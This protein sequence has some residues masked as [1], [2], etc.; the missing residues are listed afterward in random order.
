MGWADGGGLVFGW[1]LDEGI[2]DPKQN[3]PVGGYGNAVAALERHT[4]ADSRAAGLAHLAL[5]VLP[6]TGLGWLLQRVS[7]DRPITRLVLTTLATWTVLGGRSLQREG[8][9]VAAL[10]A[11]HD[12]PEAR[13]RIRSL[14]G[15]DPE[16]LDAE[17]LARAAVESVAENTS[18]AVVAPLF[19]GALFGIPGL[20][21]YRA[22]NTLDAMIGHHNER[23]ERFGWAAARLD[24]LVN[25]APARLAALLTVPATFF[26]GGN[27]A[28]VWPVVRRDAGKHPSPNAGRIEAAFAGGLG[29]RLGGSNSYGGRWED[30]GTLGDGP[31]PTPDDLPRTTMLSALVGGFA[32]MS[33]GHLARVRSNLTRRAVRPKSVRPPA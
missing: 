14:V 6:V 17:G 12:L 20:L 24:D 19:W 1:L 2:G 22:I 4:Y 5:A 27:A 13:K 26:N 16:S 33:L 11:A 32:A 8:E 3:H 21:T 15:R 9:A 23:Y 30:R 29:V 25:W 18:D 28:A 7:R 31:A 10:L